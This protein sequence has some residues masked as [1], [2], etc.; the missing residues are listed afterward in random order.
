VQ[1]TSVVDSRTAV[2]RTEDRS[3]GLVLMTCYPF[4]AVRPGGPLRYVVTVSA[5]GE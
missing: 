4:D 3:A 5:S 1:E 2:I